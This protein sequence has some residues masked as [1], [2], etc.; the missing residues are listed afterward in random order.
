MRLKD[1]DTSGYLSNGKYI[2][3]PAIEFAQLNQITS[4]TIQIVRFSHRKIGSATV[5]TKRIAPS[6][7]IMGVY[8][9]A[10]LR[11]TLNMFPPG[12]II[13]PDAKRL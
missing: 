6:V 2:I 9:E 7:S 10:L 4:I 11:L 12:D 3:Y 1:K 13:A 5:Y 8:G